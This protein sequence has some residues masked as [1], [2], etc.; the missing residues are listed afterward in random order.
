[1]A[2]KK[3]PS[4]EQV[5][6]ESALVSTAKAIGSAAGKVAAMAGV[7]PSTP[8]KPK[9][10]KLAPKNKARVPRRVKK[11]QKKAAAK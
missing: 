5:P 1:V 9:K 7:K 2:T 4:A 10:L 3:K 11:A 8:P 6:E